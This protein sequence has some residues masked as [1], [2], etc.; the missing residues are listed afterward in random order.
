MYKSFHKKRECQQTHSQQRIV[1][2]RT[3]QILLNRASQNMKVKKKKKNLIQRNQQ[4]VE[5]IKLK[6]RDL[7][8]NSVQ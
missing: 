3:K 7:M 1:D 8:R 6:N 5:I 4:K 2:N